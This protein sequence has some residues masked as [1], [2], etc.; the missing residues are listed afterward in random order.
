MSIIETAV[1]RARL[2]AQAAPK[3]KE[4]ERERE[5][6]RAAEALR[7][8]QATQPP[9]Q[10]QQALPN[11]DVMERNCVLMGISDH[12]AL[13][14]YKIM[15]TRVL[16]RLASKQWHSIAITGTDAGQG[17]TL[18]AIN[19]AIA[20]AQDPNT[21]VFLVDLDLQRP[22]IA[23][24][25]GMSF[26]KGLSDYFLSGAR[27]EEIAY[28]PVERLAVIPNAQVFEHSSEYL[29]SPR[30]AELVAALEAENPRR[31]IIYDMPPLLLS[32]DVL[33]FVPHVDGLLLVVAE[34]STA[35][36][37][38][39]KSKEFLTD[40]NVIGVVLNRSSERD[41]STYY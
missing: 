22:Q 41:D 19:L 23:S 40:I 33:T 15:R 18:T 31:V 36:R 24:Y 5:R 12:S 37:S 14:A 34:G 32:D 26:E 28:S 30:M 29:A 4:R 35:R 7:S 11:V 27:L 2:I 1:Q 17:K 6:R 10:F 13:R 20:L 25:L 3:A 38:L 8:E 16:Q 9:R 39:E 21:S